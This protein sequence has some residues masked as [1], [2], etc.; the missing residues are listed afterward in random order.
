MY[1][2]VQLTRDTRPIIEGIILAD[3]GD[4]DLLV[5]NMG[6]AT[7]LPAG[8]FVVNPAS[9]LVH[10]LDEPNAVFSALLDALPSPEIPANIRQ[11]VVRDYDT[12]HG[13]DSIWSLC[14]QISDTQK[15]KTA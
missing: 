1:V 10:A 8:Y 11:H 7:L 5:D 3:L 13:G 9:V 14:K 4:G 6:V 2:Y 15:D 12:A